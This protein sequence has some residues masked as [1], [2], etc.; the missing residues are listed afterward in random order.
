MSV[1]S[2]LPPLNP[3]LARELKQRMRGR[4][5]WLVLTLYLTVLAVIL[6]WIYVASSSDGSFDGGVDLLASATAGR[7][8]FQWLLFFMLLLVCFIV[9]GLTAGAIS[10]ERERRTMIALQLTLLRPRSIVAGKLLASLAFVVLLIVASLPLVTVPFLV[11][12][13]SLPELAKGLTMVL[14]TAI[15]L[16][17]LTLACSALLRRTQAA[18]VVAYGITLGLVLGTLLVYGAQQIPRRANGGPRPAPWILALN[19]FAA[20]AEVVH[21]RTRSEGFESPFRALS[22]LVRLTDN[23]RFTDVLAGS[24]EESVTFGPNGPVI[25]RPGPAFGPPPTVVRGPSGPIIF[26]A[27][28]GSGGFAVDGAQVQGVAVDDAARLGGVRFWIVSLVSWL[29]LAVVAVFLTVRLIRL[30][31]SRESS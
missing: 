6:R 15:T 5:V 25:G 22:E 16:A 30:P 31:A 29:L 7:A 18:T 26:D 11:G 14:A 17:C 24:S 21:G 10:G 27:G 13:V 9:P 4:H 3:V 28:P 20:T 2:A 19:P 23:D 1:V 12:G 8:I